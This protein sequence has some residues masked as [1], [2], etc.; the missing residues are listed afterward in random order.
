MLNLVT[1]HGDIDLAFTPAGQAGGFGGWRRHA[2]AQEVSGGLTVLVG[3]L[4]DVIDS[5][6]TAAP[7]PTLTA[8]VGQAGESG[9][10]GG[11][12][13]RVAEQRRHR[14]PHRQRLP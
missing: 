9:V 4:D 11:S 10:P 14:Q 8:M 6:R 7:G 13:D 3:S 2:S 1:D 5:K 12:A